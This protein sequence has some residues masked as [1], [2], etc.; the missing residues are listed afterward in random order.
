MKGVHPD[1]DGSMNNGRDAYA[2]LSSY[3]SYFKFNLYL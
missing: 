1:Y 2:L 3:Q